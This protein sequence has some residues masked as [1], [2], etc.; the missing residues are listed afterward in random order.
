MIYL[1]GSYHDYLPSRWVYYAPV[2]SGLLF[3]ALL[4]LFLLLLTVWIGK[5]QVKKTCRP[6]P[7]FYTY[8]C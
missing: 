2:F 8:P 3:P 4:Y 5:T 6:D 1:T 7:A